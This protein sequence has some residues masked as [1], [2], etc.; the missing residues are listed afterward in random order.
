MFAAVWGI[1]S[2]FGT[3]L[4]GFF[5]TKQAKIAMWQEGLIGLFLA[6]RQAGITDVA[7][8]Q[9]MA[10]VWINDSNSEHFLVRSWRPIVALTLMV[11]LIAIMTGW[12]DAPIL[13][14]N[15]IPPMIDKLLTIFGA[16]LGW[17]IG[18]RT[19]DKGIA[20]MAKSKVA[21]TIMNKIGDS[22]TEVFEDVSKSTAA[23]DSSLDTTKQPEDA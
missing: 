20:A 16:I 11:F 3:W 12:V 18:A 1:F 14:S 21:N 13:F 6:L 8:A 7:I 10:Q 15:P 2:F 23:I 22:A 4:K 5:A 19:I 9:L 17:G